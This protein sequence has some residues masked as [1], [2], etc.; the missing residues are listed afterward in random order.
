MSK[1]PS[2]SS[3]YWIDKLIAHKTIS[4]RSNLALVDEIKAYFHELGAKTLRTTNDEGTKANLFITLPGRSGTKAHGLVLSGHLDVVPVEGQTWSSDPFTMTIK[5][6]R[7][8]GRGACDMKGF[9][10]VILGMAPN[11]AA[12]PP[13]FP[14]HFALSFDEELGCLGAPL[15]IQDFI[16]KG[17]RPRAC[18]VGE[19]TGMEPVVAHKAS[20]VYNCHVH[21]KSCH[22]SQPQVG[23]NAVIYASKII[24]FLHD[25]SVDLR[26]RETQDASFTPPYGTLVVGTIE[27]GVSANTVPEFCTFSFILRTLPT[28][29]IGKFEDKIRDYIA[30]D[31]IPEMQREHATAFV[32]LER[33]AAVPAMREQISD[34]TKSLM[35]V[36]QTT[37]TGHV[38]YGTEAGLFQASSIPTLVCGP[39]SILQAH[40]PDE[41]VEL[42][43]LA[44][45]EEWL[46]NIVYP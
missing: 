16:A 37:Q 14:V 25:L 2:P 33:S 42:Q 21:G 43:Q 8:Y 44:L 41:Y 4:S 7:V 26:L 18:I 13:A 5:N 34:A 1:T 30:T 23:V 22:S 45:C 27:G 11:I 29:D 15:M 24:A 38:S 17:Y 40:K 3:L 19:P 39:G 9:V 10:G 46:H 32:T 28:T 12:N 35:A 6:S 31:V 36:L 20:R